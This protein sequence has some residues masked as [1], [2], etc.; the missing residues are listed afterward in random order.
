MEH[1]AGPQQVGAEPGAAQIPQTPGVMLGLS[2]R[3]ANALQGCI[4]CSEM[5]LSSGLLLPKPT[6]K[7][8]PGKA[9]PAAGTV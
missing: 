5:G 1:H 8:F 7:I 9:A 4:Q 6:G 2:L 3:R